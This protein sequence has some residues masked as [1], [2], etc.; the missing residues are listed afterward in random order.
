ML[1]FYPNETSNFC[2]DKASTF[3]LPQVLSANDGAGANDGEG[4]P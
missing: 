1:Y 4:I 3:T 2:F